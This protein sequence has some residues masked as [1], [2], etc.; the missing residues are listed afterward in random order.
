[1]KA[2]T[3]LLLGAVLAIFSATACGDDQEVSDDVGTTVIHDP[4]TDVPACSEWEAAPPEPE[5]A[6]NGCIDENGDLFLDAVAAVPDCEEWTRRPV[7]PQDVEEGCSTGTAD[8]DPV[9]T[10]D[11]TDGRVLFW[12]EEVWGYVGEAATAQAADAEGGAPEAE[13]AACRG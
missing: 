10:Y 1:M 12:N 3:T 13:S 4:A 9:A 8:L 11:C 7:T 6:E 5:E 2:H